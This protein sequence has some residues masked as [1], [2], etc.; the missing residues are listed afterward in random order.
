MIPTVD[1]FGS[2]ISRLIV[3]GNPFCGHTYISKTTST[4]DM[5]D[6]YTAQKIVETLFEAEAQGYGTF[7]PIADDFMLRVIRQ[8]KKEGGK[9]NWIA[10]T[11]PPVMLEVNVRLIM[12]LQPVAIFHQGTVTDNLVEADKMDELIRNI[13]IIRESGVPAGMCSHVPQTILRAEKEGW[14]ADFYMCCVHNMR[15]KVQYESSFITGVTHEFEFDAQDR[16][17]MFAAMRA[18]PKPCLAFK[19][20]SGGNIANSPNDVE[21]ALRETFENIKPADTAV[22]GVFQRDKNQLAQNARLAEK[23]LADL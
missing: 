22:V 15:K 12:Q 2:R 18:V 10:Q 1:F 19:I 17:K 13:G 7:L 3:G 23:A 6:F 14:G 21:A 9:M 16:P 11:H 20:L 4:D 8:Y 5:L